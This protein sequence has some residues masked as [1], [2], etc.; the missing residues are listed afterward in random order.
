[1]VHEEEKPATRQ[2]QQGKINI[3]RFQRV[4]PISMALLI[5]LK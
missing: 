3:Q 2:S 4:E 1:M 5:F